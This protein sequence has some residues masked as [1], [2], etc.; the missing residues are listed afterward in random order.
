MFAIDS[1]NNEAGTEN[2]LISLIRGMD[3]Q[4]FELF[5]VCIEDGEPLRRLA[6]Q[7]TPLVFPMTRVFSLN[8]LRQILRLH[9]QINRLQID[10]LHAFFTRTSVLGVL[11]APGSNCQVV[12]TS[13]RNMGHWYTPFY[14]TVFRLLNHMTSRVVANSESAKRAAVEIEG[15]PASRIDVLYNGVEL[16]RFSGAGD[17]LLLDRLGVD[18]P[19]PPAIEE[20]V[21]R[22]TRDNVQCKIIAGADYHAPC[23]EAIL[24]KASYHLSHYFSVVGLSERFEESLAGF[25]MQSSPFFRKCSRYRRMG[26]EFKRTCLAAGP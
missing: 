11:A 7:A 26:S 21:E 19:L 9:N 24:E 16:E 20:F 22:S 5:V 25:T 14:R 18:A 1:L 12:L 17:R 13:R 8:G 4:R 10:I 3:S 15:L 6:P 2:Q 23:T